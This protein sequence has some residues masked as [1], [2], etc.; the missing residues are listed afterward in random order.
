ME[1]NA[2][3]DV[4]VKGFWDLRF[5]LRRSYFYH[6]KRVLF[7]RTLLFIA[8]G[9]EAALMSTAAAFLFNDSSKT[10]SQWAV[11][12]SAILSFI[13]IWFG[14]EKRIQVNM[15]KKARFLD[16]EDRI[17]IKESDYSEE[18]LEK[19]VRARRKIERDDDVVLPCV[20]ALARND[21]CR[22]LGL[23]EDRRLNVLER[24]VGRILPIPY[25]KKV[26]QEAT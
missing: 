14:A 3:D 10:F 17:P 2:M 21:A 16:L 12:V 18:L 22:A 24:I 23:T 15:E 13:V 25:K 4:L 5:G 20:D 26:A 6:E 11:L 7:W 8:H 1:K 19:L 9:M